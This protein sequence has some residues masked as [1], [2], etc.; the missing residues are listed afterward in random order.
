M[1]FMLNMIQ[2]WLEER[3][4]TAIF[5]DFDYHSK[6]EGWNLPQALT[7]NFGFASLRYDASILRDPNVV[8]TGFDGI[9]FLTCDGQQVSQL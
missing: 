1:H 7:L 9:Q 6:T 4:G 3:N 5:N 2:N 8:V